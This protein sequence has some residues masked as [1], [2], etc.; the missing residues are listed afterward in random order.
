MCTYSQVVL[1]V[2]CLGWLSVAAGVE[3][4]DSSSH[5]LLEGGGG[6]ELHCTGDSSWSMCSWEW[7]ASTTSTCNVASS[8]KGVETVCPNSRLAVTGSTESCSAR[9]DVM[10]LDDAGTFTCKLLQLGEGNDVTVDSRQIKVEVAVPAAVAF[11][12]DITEVQT[13]KWRVEEGSTY[14]VECGGMA[15]Y[16]AA[17]IAV[18]LG[19]GET[20]NQDDNKLEAEE[21]DTVENEDDARLLDVLGVFLLTP[22]RSDCGK[23]IKCEGKQLNEEGELLFGNSVVRHKQI[24]VVFPPREVG[25]GDVFEFGYSEEHGS[26]SMEVVIQFQ[27]H[28]PPTNQQVTWHLGEATLSPGEN[29]TIN[30]QHKEE[31]E[32][33]DQEPGENKHTDLESITKYEA[34][35]VENDEEGDLV[36]VRLVIHNV[37]QQDSQVENFVVVSNGVGGGDGGEILQI[38]FMV[39][40]EAA[41]LIETTTTT[42]MEVEV[43]KTT[44]QHQHREQDEEEAVAPEEPDV[45]S[46]GAGGGTVAAIV[47]ILVALTITATVVAILKKRERLCFKPYQEVNQKPDPEA[48]P[49]KT[50]IKDQ[51]KKDENGQKDEKL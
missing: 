44:T 12:G 24:M 30:I 10:E 19:H 34:K 1:L 47:L 49:H 51:Q 17:D 42:T 14:T 7:L 20:I 13:E 39:L 2:G 35:P 37:E 48:Q 22:E 26:G 4:V 3:I 18:S 5:V 32:E 15:G 8:A 43:E 45:Q 46:S 36:V 21:V 6:V 25:T 28:P 29:Y 23:F 27:S 50:I 9:V 16:P 38:P 41:P 11:A 31:E 40:F 33:E